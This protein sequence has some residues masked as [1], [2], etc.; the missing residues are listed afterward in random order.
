MVYD[1][2]PISHNELIQK[3]VKF[4]SYSKEK[5]IL[6]GWHGERYHTPYSN[7]KKKQTKIVAS[8]P[9]IFVEG[10]PVQLYH[11]S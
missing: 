5:N 4:Y 3:L 1:K 6:F 9:T 8:N 7:W 2:A 11:N 10:W